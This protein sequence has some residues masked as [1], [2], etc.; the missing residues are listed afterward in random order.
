MLTNPPPSSGGILIAYALGSLERQGG[1]SG[2]EGLVAATDA[3]NSPRNE[4]FA[5]GLY[6]E[7]LEEALLDPARLVLK[8]APARLH[9][10]HRGARRR[11]H[12]R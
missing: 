8:V 6:G 12:L 11:R 2:A 7:E 5:E 10:P 3:A 9:H 1:G 4:E